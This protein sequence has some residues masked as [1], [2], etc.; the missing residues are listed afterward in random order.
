[1]WPMAIQAGVLLVLHWCK[2]HITAAA[3]C[4]CEVALSQVS[5]ITSL[6]RY[7][8][9]AAAGAAAGVVHHHPG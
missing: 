6:L 4:V 2:L 3:L 7:Y 1:M 9:P 5:S 8:T